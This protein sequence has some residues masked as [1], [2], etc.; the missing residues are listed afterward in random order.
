VAGNRPQRILVVG[1]GDAGAIVVRE[2]LNNPA[3]GMDVVGFIN[4]DARKRSVLIAGVP[5]LGNRRA[6]PQLV[7]DYDVALVVRQGKNF[8]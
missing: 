6:I 3:V 4:D 5:V 8:G 7:T 2:M 1:A